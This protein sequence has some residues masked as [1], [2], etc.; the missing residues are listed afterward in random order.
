MVKP[1]GCGARA[2]SIMHSGR[3]KCPLGLEVTGGNLGGQIKGLCVLTKHGFGFNPR[4]DMIMEPMQ[5]YS[6]KFPKI[7]LCVGGGGVG[8][9]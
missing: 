4:I 8:A 5:M 7:K 6:L 1:P 9:Q 3:L 2:R